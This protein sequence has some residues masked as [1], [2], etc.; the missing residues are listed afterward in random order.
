LDLTQKEGHRLKGC[1]NVDTMGLWAYDHYTAIRGSF[2]MFSESP[3]FW[4]IQNTTI[5][6]NTFVSKQPLCAKIHFCQR[7]SGWY[8]QSWKPFC[9]RFF[10]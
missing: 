10:S 1:T 4:E 7:L 9:K 5:V 6:E 8:K 2:K 3:H